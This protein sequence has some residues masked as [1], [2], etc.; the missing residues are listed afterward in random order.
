MLTVLLS[1]RS[2]TQLT[3]AVPEKIIRLGAAKFF[4]P[5]RLFVLTFSATGSVHTQ[6]YQTEPHLDI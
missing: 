3:L 1:F 2:A 5:L 6:S 4:R